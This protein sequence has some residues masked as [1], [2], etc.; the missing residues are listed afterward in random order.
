MTAKANNSASTTLISD[1]ERLRDLVAKETELDGEGPN[2]D[3]DIRSLLQRIQA[4]EDLTQGVEGKL[5]GIL[6]N[7][8]KMLETLEVDAESTNNDKEAL[9]KDALPLKDEDNSQ[10]SDE[11]CS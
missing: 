2:G 5:D 3:A 9:A 1:L 6:S 10:P 4:V 8:D 7:L 11:Q